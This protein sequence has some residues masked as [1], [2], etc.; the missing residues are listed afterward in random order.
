M[1]LDKGL[2]ELPDPRVPEEIGK[3]SDPTYGATRDREVLY[4]E[5]NYTGPLVIDM[6]FVREF[7]FDEC[8][9]ITL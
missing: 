1:L 9:I 6:N 7:R 4:I 5:E 8:D 3:V 2:V